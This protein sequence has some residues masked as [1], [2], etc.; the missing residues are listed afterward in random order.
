MLQDFPFKSGEL[1][2]DRTPSA[3]SLA[4]AGGLSPLGSA[5]GLVFVV[6]VL[7]FLKR[8]MELLPLIF[9]SLFRARGVGYLEHSVRSNHDRNLLASLLLIPLLLMTFRFRLWDAAFLQGLSPDGRLAALAGVLSAY[10]LLRVLMYA[11]LKPRRRSDYYQLAR[12]TSYTFFILLLILLLISLG[13]LYLFSCSDALIRV[14]LLLEISLF[15]AAFLW[16]RTQILSLSCNHLRT[17]LYLCGLEILPTSA[18]VV[19]ALLL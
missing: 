1:L 12:R 10:L 7:L 11:L 18:L 6:A 3:E 14:V 5:L 2:L 4:E 15:Y 9:D 16:R 8:I 19:S 13:I 17:F